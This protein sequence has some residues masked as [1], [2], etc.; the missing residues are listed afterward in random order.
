MRNFL[1]HV[2]AIATLLIPALL[3]SN[4]ILCLILISCVSLCLIFLDGSKNIIR[5]FIVV[6]ISGS[7]A[8]IVAIHFGAWQYKNTFFLGIPYYLPFT[9]GNAGIFIK[10]LTKKYK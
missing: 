5:F 6:A 8:E 7:L 9:W 2:A 10:F 1:F 3:F 4:P